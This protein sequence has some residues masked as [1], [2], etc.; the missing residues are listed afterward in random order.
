MVLSERARFDVAVRL[1]TPDGLPLG[2]LFTFLSGLYFRGKLAYARAFAPDPADVLVIVPGAGLVVPETPVT[3]A[4]MHAIAAIGV[5]PANA[6]FREPLARSAR[7]LA[8]TLGAED[9]VVLL[10]SI[11]S[12]K[13]V[14][15]LGDAFGARLR[16]PSDFVGRGDMSRGGLL[17]RCVRA[18][19]ELAYAPVAG[20]VRRGRR[21][22]RLAPLPRRTAG[23]AR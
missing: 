1:R 19:S 21:P 23:T 4:A 13:Y 5:D 15:V 2:D 8:R 6:A 18:G 14:D 7:A 20:T 12:A 3:L 10:G 22:P 16:F 17:L 11:A 9:D